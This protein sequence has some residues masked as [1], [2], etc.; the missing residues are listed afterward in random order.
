MAVTPSVKIEKT[1]TAKG[2]TRRWSNRY[3]FN[4]GTPADATHWHTLMDN[5]VTAEK[6]CLASTHTIV[7][8]VGYNAGSDLPVASKTYSTAGTFTLAGSDLWMP[9]VMAYLMRWSTTARTSKNHPVYLFS[10]FHGVRRDSSGDIN[11]IQTT[12]VSAYNTYCT[13]W[14][15]GFSDGSIT[16]VRAGPNGA[17]GSADLRSGTTYA[18]HRDFPS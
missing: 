7:A 2:V 10:Y 12:Q 11:A 8:A 16:A 6:A 1:F 13:A 15:T 9:D 18:T 17:T 3:H 5:I 14:V 4:G